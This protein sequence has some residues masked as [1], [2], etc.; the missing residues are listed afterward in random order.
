MLLNMRKL[1]LGL[2]LGFLIIS[3]LHVII[4]RSEPYLN[5]QAYME[6]NDQIKS[7]FGKIKFSLVYVV[8]IKNSHAKFLIYI[9]GEKKHSS[10]KLYGNEQNGAWIIRRDLSG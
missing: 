5:A 4:T 8:T 3:I 6:N 10:I 9:I 7:E 2:T 1:F